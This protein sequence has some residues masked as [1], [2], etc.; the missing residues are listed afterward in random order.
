[1]NNSINMKR[2]TGGASRQGKCADAT[3][4]DRSD[5][6]TAGGLRCLQ[7]LCFALPP[8]SSGAHSAMWPMRL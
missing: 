7:E 1:M 6:A 4:L 5:W 8:D 3:L 2:Y